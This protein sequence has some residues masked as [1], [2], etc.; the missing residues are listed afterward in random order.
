MAKQ[1]DAI[2]NFEACPWLELTT[3]EFVLK[4]TYFS[5]GFYE[6]PAIA[7]AYT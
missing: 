1:K 7:N 4:K 2:L 5:L 3:P 6:A